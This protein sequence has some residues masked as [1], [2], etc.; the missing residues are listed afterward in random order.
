[1]NNSRT[2]KECGDKLLGRADQQYCSD[3]C[4]NAWHNRQKAGT[5]AYVRKVTGILKKN[6]NILAELTP[7]GKAN[8]DRKALD[9]LGFNFD[10]YTNTYT[11]RK[12]DVYFFCYEYAYVPFNDHFYLLVKREDNLFA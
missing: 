8:S 7:N 10:F 11:N 6:R 3:A 9:K 5:N 12:G 1:M 4:R 2:C